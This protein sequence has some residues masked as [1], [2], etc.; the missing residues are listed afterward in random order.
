M[1]TDLPAQSRAPSGRFIPVPRVEIEGETCGCLALCAAPRTRRSL[2]LGPPALNGRTFDF[3]V[4]TSIGSRRKVRG[5]REHSILPHG[6]AFARRDVLFGLLSCGGGRSLL[7]RP[8]ISLGGC[9]SIRCGEGDASEASRLLRAPFETE[10][11]QVNA[12]VE[13][14]SRFRTYV[15]GSARNASSERK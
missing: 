7:H 15:G 11:M 10:A 2:P 6:H 3:D 1:S 12:L 8:A 14:V 4:A 5:A 9:A 13:Q